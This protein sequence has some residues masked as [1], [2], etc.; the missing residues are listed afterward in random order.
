MHNFRAVFLQQRRKS[1]NTLDI[2]GCKFNSLAAAE[3]NDN[4]A[5]ELSRSI[6]SVR[7]VPDRWL[8]VRL[9]DAAFKTGCL[10]R[11]QERSGSLRI[12]AA[13]DQCPLSEPARD[14]THVSEASRP[15]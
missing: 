7:N 12:T 4:V 3:A 10:Q 6:Y 5:A 8:T 15:K 11:G 2:H 1:L 14:R 9:E 13:D